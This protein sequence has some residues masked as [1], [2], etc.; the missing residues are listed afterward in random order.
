MHVGNSAESQLQIGNWGDLL[1][2]TW[3]YVEEGHVLHP[4]GARRLADAVDFLVRVWERP[5]ASLWELGET[6]Q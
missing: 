3:H 1:D 2:A 6:K 4:H 5:D